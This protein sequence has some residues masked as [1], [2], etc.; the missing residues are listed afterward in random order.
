M[1]SKSLF[2][3]TTALLPLVAS[4]GQ[5][6]IITFDADGEDTFQLVGGDISNGQ[7]LVS[8]DEFWGVV[9]A[10]GD[11]AADFGRVTGTNFSISNGR[12]G[13][14]PAV[15]K[16]DPVDISNNTIVRLPIQRH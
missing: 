16:Y 7:I 1:K 5:K 10:A 14:T 8:G 15:F 2:A 13:A 4:L 6:Q 12:E 9:R 11:L 3:A